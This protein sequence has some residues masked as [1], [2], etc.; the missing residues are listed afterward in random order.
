V[1]SLPS[2]FRRFG[3]ASFPSLKLWGLAALQI[4]E[5]ACSIH[6]NSTVV[7]PR[8]FGRLGLGRTGVEL[9]RPQRFSL[10][11]SF[12]RTGRRENEDILGAGGSKRR[13]P[14]SLSL[15]YCMDGRYVFGCAVGHARTGR[16]RTCAGHGMY[17]TDGWLT[18]MNDLPGLRGRR[19]VRRV[20]GLTVRSPHPRSQ[21]GASSPSRFS[22]G[23]LK[24]H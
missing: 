10:V 9:V 5:G 14:L 7:W 2:T 13:G 19:G 11:A 1:Y 8:L 22:A 24:G 6:G 3:A 18:T 12:R 16:K 21:I 4:A 23:E 15:A 20:M 17:L